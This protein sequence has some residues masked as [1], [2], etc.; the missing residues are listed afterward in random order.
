MAGEGIE[1]G[2]EAI[3]SRVAP[4]AVLGESA[5]VAVRS[6]AFDDREVEP[7]ALFCC[8]PGEHNDG[9]DFAAAARAAGAVAFVCEHS[10]GE[11]ADGAPQLV[12]APG[13]ARAAMARAACALYGDPATALHTVGVTGT[14]GKTT[15]TYLLRSI[16]E[17]HGWRTG[18]LGTLDGARTTPEA[19]R[20][21]QAL[22]RMRDTGCVAGAIEVSSHALVQHRV[23]GIRFEV[24]IFTNLSQ[25]HLDFH[26][27]MDAYFSA[28]ATLF[29][30]ERA[31]VSV[32]NSDDPYGR[33]LLE[34]PLVPTVS[35][36]LADVRD[37]DVGLDLST[38]RLGG[39]RVRLRLGGEFNVYNA[40]GAAAAARVL[41]I[42]ADA[43]V[44]GLE[45]AQ[46]VPGRFEAIRSSDGV[47]VLVDYA[48]TPAG[49]E[50]V[51]LA[52]RRTGSTAGRVSVV[53]GCGGDRDRGKRPA[54][55]AVASRLADLVVLTSDNP[56]SEDP[57]AI[58]E[59]VRAGVGD[60]SRC[61]VEPDRR[62]AIA[63]ALR[64]AR[65]GDVVV[66]A[67]K[68][69]ETTQQFADATVRFDDREVVREELVTLGRA[70]PD[71]FKGRDR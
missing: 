8:L 26:E 46:P 69:H 59:E 57:I 63:G 24:G 22:A 71:W 38:F 32:V 40:L 17:Q 61:V 4:I 39:R 18:I 70:V 10:L 3:V 67:G 23:D 15:T 16:F 43:I 52:A 44:A 60:P 1:V 65:A 27:T 66:V 68:G 2:L 35:F 30:P 42:E 14:N 53:F 54:M 34:R 50:Q 55:G 36:S 20:L 11:A 19:P 64:G 31:R 33:R 7:G 9:H 21:Q 28:K 56:R 13:G 37:L 49:L 62:R 5:G 48:H 51:L 12:V 29:T 45:A 58:I 6:V 25:E 47:I 41:G